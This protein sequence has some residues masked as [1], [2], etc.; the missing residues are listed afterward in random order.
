MEAPGG[1]LSRREA[2]EIKKRQDEEAAA[3]V[4]YFLY[5]LIRNKYV[6]INTFLLLRFS[7]NLW[8]LSKK[9]LQK[10]LKYGSKQEHLT[11]ALEVSAIG[12]FFNRLCEI[13]TFNI[14]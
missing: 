8:R 11:L 13:F 14:F 2:E 9:H 5:A 3:H 10:Y 6:N 7:K 12:F 4:N 1:P